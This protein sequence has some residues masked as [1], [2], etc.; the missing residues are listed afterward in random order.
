MRV[1]LCR[2]CSRELAVPVRGTGREAETKVPFG[3]LFDMFLNNV[4]S[5]KF[6]IALFCLICLFSMVENQINKSRVM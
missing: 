3:R 4:I 5:K 1:G 2:L 6:Q